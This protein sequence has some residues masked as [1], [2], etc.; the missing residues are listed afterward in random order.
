MGQ[1]LR[2]SMQ[3]APAARRRVIGGK[4][5]LSRPFRLGVGQY[6]RYRAQIIHLGYL[7]KAALAPQ[8]GAGEVNQLVA[9][10][11]HYEASFV[12][13]NRQWRID[14]GE[15]DLPISCDF[16]FGY[17]YGLDPEIQLRNSE[18]QQHA[19]KHWINAAL[20]LHITLTRR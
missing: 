4:D 2:R 16:D 17:G 8:I 1:R 11:A 3:R 7:L 13:F 18:Y 9:A 20:D 19:L 12:Y 6:R 14:N 15:A 10:A 5:R